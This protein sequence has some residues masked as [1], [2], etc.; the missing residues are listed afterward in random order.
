[1]AFGVAL[2]LSCTTAF[3]STAGTEVANTATLSFQIQG[4]NKTVSSN[5]VRFVIAEKLDVTVV[6]DAPKAPVLGNGEC[7]FGFLVTNQGNGAESFD[8]TAKVEGNGASVLTIAA[9]ADDNGLYDPAI[10]RQVPNARLPLA[11]DQKTRVFVV[12]GGCPQFDEVSL[13]ATAV[14]GSGAPGTVLD[15]KGDNGGDAVVGDTGGTGTARIDRVFAR[16]TGPSLVKSQSVLA[17]DG[18][19]SAIRGAIVTYQLDANFPTAAA[20]VE[21]ED[22]IPAGTEYVAG[23]LT[24]DGSALSDLGD[25]DSGLFDGGMV[26][27]ALGDVPSGTRTITFQVRIQ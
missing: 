1:M 8:L 22:P 9:D 25:G 26:R 5:T 15:G 7:A 3:A 17:P 24:V 6:A 19:T 10:D 2:A 21:I 27:I 12:V 20:G 13:T 18:S 14:S 16:L 4:V 11:P 23:S